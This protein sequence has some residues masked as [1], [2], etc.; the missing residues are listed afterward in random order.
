MDPIP[1][2]V[3]A[4]EAPAAT[5]ARAMTRTPTWSACR[6]LRA[7]RLVPAPPG[8]GQSSTTTASRARDA[9]EQ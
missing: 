4:D 5:G 6:D 1:I 3:L 8:P 9:G 2:T 7:R